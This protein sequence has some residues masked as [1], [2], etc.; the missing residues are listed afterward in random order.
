[1][2]NS[3]LA[4][5]IRAGRGLRSGGRVW[6]DRREIRRPGI[7]ALLV[8]SRGGWRGQSVRVWPVNYAGEESWGLVVLVGGVE[9]PPFT[10]T[11]LDLLE[12]RYVFWFAWYMFD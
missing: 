11:V 12:F 9:A 6:S 1:M 5:G 7:L 3:G 10:T 2:R 8:E 4:G